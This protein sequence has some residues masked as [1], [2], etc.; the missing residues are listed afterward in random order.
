MTFRTR[1]VMAATIAVMMAVVLGSIAAYVVAHNSL[2]GSIDVNLSQGAQFNVNQ[3]NI[4]NVCSPTTAG[5]CSQV[6][7]ANG[8]VNPNDPQSLPIPA[9]VKQMAAS[10]GN[11]SPLFFSTTVGNNGTT[12]EVRELVVPLAPGYHYQE[13]YNS[14]SYE[15]PAGGALQM[16]SPLTG[17]NQE[18]G[19][20]ALALWIIAFLGVALAVLLGLVVGR[21]VLGPL[22]SLTSTVEE[23]ADTTDVSRRLDP[24]G[25]D[26]LGRLRRAFNRLLEALDSSRDSQ[27]QLVLDA[28][29]E[30][31]TPLTSLRTNM[32]VARRM[33]E[34]EPVE[35]EVLIGDVL[36]Q[37]D[38]L[39]TVVAD[40]AEL[41][42]GEQPPPIS[43]PVRL[44]AVVEETV[45][46][47]TTHG[48]SRG[49]TFNAFI[50]PSW[51]MGSK[52]RIERAIGNLLDN[53]LKW[54]PDGGSVEI[55]CSGGTVIVRDHGH[56]IDESDID[57]LFD[58]FYRAPTARG[59]PGSGLGLAIVAQVA[60]EEG[61]SVEAQQ[62]PGGGALFRFSLP[63]IT[64]PKEA[65]LEE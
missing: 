64:P 22:N 5:Q 6:V 31:R 20:L 9:A 65:G 52:P 47:A 41:A 7:W 10:Q 39:T 63:E 13:G 21:A 42:R 35:R 36:T 45:G 60:R 61:G 58:R 23:L 16:S 29:H 32:E 33:D 34:L 12:T 24:G 46:V 40:L 1:L 43:E 56:G 48:R 19:H 55:S 3:Q 54:S 27:R 37:L 15:M 28:S 49:V 30:L 62:A 59:L 2:V 44:H 4:P 14:Y 17:V 26:E 18:L 53:A 11:G 51:V 50:A 38:E 8:A 57:H 25:M